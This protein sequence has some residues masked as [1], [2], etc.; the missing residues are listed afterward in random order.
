MASLTLKQRGRFTSDGTAKKILLPGGADYF[1]VINQTQL[2]TT[3]A[4]GRGVRF[5]WTPDMAA[6]S[7]I[8]WK[9]T[10]ST[11]ALNMV[12]ASS[13]GFTYRTAQQD[14]G[15]PKTITAITAANPAVVSSTSHGFSNG[16]R[17]VIYGT[18]GMLQIGG[19]NF[20]VSSVS[21]NAFTLAGLDA[22]GFAAAATAG[23]ARKIAPL[24]E[25]EPES[26]FITN[27]TQATS[28][29]VTTAVEH[30][31]V[32]GQ[33]MYFSVPAEFGMSQMNAKQ[34]R[35]TAVATNTITVDIDSS[36]FDAFAFPASTATPIAFPMVG[37][38]GSRNVYNY[39]EIPYH[40]GQFVPYMLLASGAQSP[41]G[42]TSD[43]I[44]WMAFNGYYS[45]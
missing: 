39:T 2:A 27:I 11:D 30:D 25:V 18:T 42:S 9:K 43:V 33:V 10:D 5:E 45:A 6:D 44:D 31:Y 26:L 8:E 16:D 32:V 37:P 1:L 34:G 13:G 29:V 4:T 14:P 22:S 19:M 21:A 35:I 40:T 36:G 7:A 20:T 41:A 12:L 24:A 28:A 15:A 17:V 38:Q 23:F 3:Q